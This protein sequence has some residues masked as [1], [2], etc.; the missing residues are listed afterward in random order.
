MTDRIDCV[1]IGAGVI[2]L[3]IA[4]TLANAGHD[5]IVLESADDIG[6]ETSS[7][8]SEVIHA[9]I[10]YAK[11]SLKAKF[12]VDGKWQLY[13][14]CESHKVPHQRCGKLIV[15]TTDAELDIL[16][17]NKQKAEDNGVDD[18]SYLTAAEVHAMEPALNATGA[19]LS[20]ST[21]IIDS[22]SLMLSYQGEAEDHGAVI[23]FLTRAIGGDVLT[24]GF[25]IRAESDG[26]TFELECNILINAAGLYAPAFARNLNGLDQ[27]HVPIPYY[28]KGSYY[29]LEGK[30]PFKRLIYPVPASASLGVHATIDL[31]GRTRFGPDQEWVDDVDYTVELSR[32]EGF[33]AAVRRYWPGLEDGKLVPA[34]SGVRPKIQPPD[35]PNTDFLIQ[36]P[37][38]H[39]IPGLI[40]LFGMESPGLTS[41]LAIAKHVQGLL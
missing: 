24:D 37:A 18:L 11:D 8:N 21:G 23:S 31:A 4:R 41:S 26:E 2:G 10:Y 14:H 27:N 29:S 20:P 6:T 38:N 19:L 3:S 32:A 34:Y 30:Q 33:Y 15:A 22:H 9:G 35:E 25:R 5:V 39:G 36:G 28:C 40:N 7:R 17:Q 12:C 13:D 1:V 16:A